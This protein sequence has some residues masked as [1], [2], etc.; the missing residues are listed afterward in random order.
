MDIIIFILMKY[1]VIT[2]GMILCVQIRSVLSSCDPPFASVADSGGSY[3]VKCDTTCLTCYDAAIN[4]CVTCPTDFTFN[5]NT[6]Y[7]IPPYT[8]SINTV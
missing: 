8:V 1:N 6:S 3:C 5:D 2:W 7:C 4:N